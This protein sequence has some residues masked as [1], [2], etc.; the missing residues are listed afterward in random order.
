MTAVHSFLQCSLYTSG[1]SH[2][3]QKHSNRV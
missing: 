2:L 3:K 1:M